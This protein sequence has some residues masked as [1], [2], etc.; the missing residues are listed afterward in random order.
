LDLFLVQTLSTGLTLPILALYGLTLESPFVALRV[1]PISVH[2]ATLG[3]PPLKNVSL[4][5]TR[6]MDGLGAVGG[7]AA[8]LAVLTLIVGCATIATLVRRAGIARRGELGIRAAVGATRSALRAHVI[9]PLT[10]RV[11]FGA[12]SGTAL[13]LALFALVRLLTPSVLTVPANPISLPV[14][15]AILMPVV[16]AWSGARVEVHTALRRFASPL[17]L[18]SSTRLAPLGLGGAYFGL[19]VGI[20]ATVGTLAKSQSYA[21]VAPQEWA[22]ARDTLLLEVQDRGPEES[23]SALNAVRSGDDARDW[24]LVSS[25][26]FEGLGPAGQEMAECDCIMGLISSPYTRMYGQRHSV[27]PGAF[28]AA[29]ISVLRGRGFTQ[30]DGPDAEGVVVI[31][32]GHLRRFPGVD[33]VGKLLHIE[34]VG[35]DTEWYRIVGVVDVPKPLDIATRGIPIPGVYFSALQHPPSHA[36]LF[37][38]DTA[39]LDEAESVA[40]TALAGAGLRGR[41][42]GT[43]DRRL[44]EWARPLTWFALLIGFASFGAFIVG[45]Y[46]VATLTWLNVRSRTTELGVRRAMGARAGQIRRLVTREVGEVAAIGAVFGSILGVGF[47]VGLADRYRAVEGPDGGMIAAVAGLLAL[48]A[49]LAALGPAKR[50]AA[51]TPIEAIGDHTD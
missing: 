11:L 47:T 4:P 42:L 43:L 2:A 29:G 44:A 14:V 51:V 22:E 6:V 41:S 35:L 19:I 16:A 40:T 30:E 34:G 25:G 12:T 33:P 5:S 8:S 48:A 26:A 24:H 18:Q 3:L 27:T 31:D 32:A 37:T 17:T 36:Q 1:A 21:D 49:V 38:R 7:V 10:R 45:V 39:A 15:F 13:G 50:A 9:G 46:G 28:E 20:L 23:L